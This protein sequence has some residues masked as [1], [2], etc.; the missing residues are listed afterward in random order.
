MKE[1]AKRDDGRWSTT[2]RREKTPRGESAPHPFL[3]VS[4]GGGEE[5]AKVGVARV[6]EFLVMYGQDNFSMND[7]ANKATSHI[8]FMVQIKEISSTQLSNISLKFIQLSNFSS[9]FIQNSRS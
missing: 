9:K 3:G 8:I 2:V 5:G 4:P 6:G 7:L 1:R